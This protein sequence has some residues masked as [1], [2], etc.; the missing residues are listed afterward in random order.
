MKTRMHICEIYLEA[1]IFKWVLIYERL[2]TF[3]SCQID[4]MRIELKTVQVRVRYL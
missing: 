4:I 1:L 2:N 3:L